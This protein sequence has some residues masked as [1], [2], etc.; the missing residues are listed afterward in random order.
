MPKRNAAAQGRADANHAE[1]VKAYES[2]HCG[3]VDTHAMGGGF[4]DVLVHFGGYCAPVEIKTKRGKLNSAQER[5][6]RDWRGP[7]I[8]IVR[9]SDDV[10]SHVTRVRSLLAQMSVTL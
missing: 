3:V 2:L 6:L 1:I 8:E 10:I 4:P 9:S 7:K 5:F